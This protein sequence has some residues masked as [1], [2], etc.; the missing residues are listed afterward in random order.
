MICAPSLA[1]SR[2][3]CSCLSSI[4]SLSP[5]QVVWVMAARTIVIGVSSPGGT[6]VIVRRKHFA[7]VTF[8]DVGVNPSTERPPT[9]PAA[10]LAEA[11]PA[12]GARGT[13]HVLALYAASRV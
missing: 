7:D 10:P 2:A 13:L 3:N 6:F 1:A 5:V 12:V 8:G 11:G 9:M 4:D